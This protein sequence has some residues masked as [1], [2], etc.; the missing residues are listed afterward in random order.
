V[1]RKLPKCKPSKRRLAQGVTAASPASK[2]AAQA[3]ATAGVDPLSRAGLVGV[4]DL[5]LFLVEAF[6]PVGPEDEPEKF[7]KE[8]VRFVRTAD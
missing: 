7:G 3:T 5:G 2:D 4:L 1:F 6:V 8:F